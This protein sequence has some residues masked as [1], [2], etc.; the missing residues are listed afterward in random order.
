MPVLTITD[1]MVQ[2]DIVRGEGEH[3]AG[4]AGPGRN[5]LVPGDQVCSSDRPYGTIGRAQRACRSP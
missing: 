4:L 1:G 3:D 5:K 2:V